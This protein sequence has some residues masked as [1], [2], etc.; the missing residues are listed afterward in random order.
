MSRSL[1]SVVH[2]LIIVR[3]P[4]PSPTS[5]PAPRL[6]TAGKKP[7][8]RCLHSI[9]FNPYKRRE[10]TL[11]IG[12]SSFRQ[13]QHTAEPLLPPP[14]APHTHNLSVRWLRIWMRKYNEMVSKLQTRNALL[15]WGFFVFPVE[16]S[17]IPV[18]I[19]VVG[20]AATRSAKCE[21]LLCVCVVLCG[22]IY[23]SRSF[24]SIRFVRR[25][26]VASATLAILRL[27]TVGAVCPRKIIGE[28]FGV[29]ISRK[30]L[31]LNK[32]E[33]F[34]TCNDER[35]RRRDGSGAPSSSAIHHSPGGQAAARNRPTSFR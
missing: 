12:T 34:E 2:R 14:L 27:F 5:S 11:L 16:P 35:S 32:I 13:R 4:P 18:T 30:M 19:G 15:G 26:L 28:R 25:R 10:I 6:P 3:P 22:I 31:R 23:A 33:W 1:V 21:N 8:H 17:L 24:C 20:Y 7:N 29:V 9:L